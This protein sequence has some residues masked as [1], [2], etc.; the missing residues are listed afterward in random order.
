MLREDWV[1]IKLDVSVEMPDVL[2]LSQLRGHGLQAGEEPLP[3]STETPPAPVFDENILS[4]LLQFG[5]HRE[6]CKRALHYTNNA[7]VN[8]AIDWLNQHMGDHDIE[9]PFVPPGTDTSKG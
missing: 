7:G 1:P 4:D 3:D 9:S 2:D 6:A 5:F 8:E